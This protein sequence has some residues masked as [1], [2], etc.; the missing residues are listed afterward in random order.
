VLNSRN[1]SRR[2]IKTVFLDSVLSTTLKEERMV[3]AQLYQTE[4]EIRAA[5]AAHL[6]ELVRERQEVCVVRRCGGPG[7]SGTIESY[8]P[9][10]DEQYDEEDQDALFVETET[11]RGYIFRISEIAT[12]EILPTRR[13]TPDVAYQRMNEMVR[14]VD[15][16]DE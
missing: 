8:I 5:I 16:K 1:F 4:H 6:V 2:S 7:V 3:Q 12:L 11:N 14:I 10:W 15:I 9:Q 13:L